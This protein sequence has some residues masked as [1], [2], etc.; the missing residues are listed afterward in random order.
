MK[1]YLLIGER[2][3]LTFWKITDEEELNTVSLLFVLY[4]LFPSFTPLLPSSVLS[5]FF[6]IVNSFE[7][8]FYF[9][10]LKKSIDIFFV[11]IKMTFTILKLTQ[12]NLNWNQ[13]NFNSIQKLSSYTVPLLLF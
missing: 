2:N 1:V 4:I 9:L 13:L 3:L 12:Y 10:F 6:I 5:W 7:V 11:L 8:P